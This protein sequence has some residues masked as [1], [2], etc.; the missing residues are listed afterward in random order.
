MTMKTPACLVLRD[1][2]AAATLVNVMTGAAA[3]RTIGLFA[4]KERM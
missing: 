1:A 4:A 2:T 3:F